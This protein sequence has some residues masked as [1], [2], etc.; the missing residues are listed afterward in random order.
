MAGR[1][2]LGS[3]L[4]GPGTVPDAAA[5]G[6]AGKHPG[7]RLGRPAAGP[8]SVATFLRRVGGITIDWVLCIFVAQGLLRSLGRPDLLTLAVLLVEH[9]LLVGTLGATV[10]HRLLGMR[11]E[12]LD[13]R[14]PGPVRALVRSVLLVLVVP[15]LLSDR[16][17][18]G[19]HDRAAGTVVVSTR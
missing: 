7:A 14:P 19:L 13:G 12:T 2:D 10:G 17:T 11:V 15:A 18:R 1:R 9:V 8:G 4:N 3:W 5:E 16:D 6:S